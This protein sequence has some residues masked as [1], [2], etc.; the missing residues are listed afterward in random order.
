MTAT[1]LAA[2]ALDV[3]FTQLVRRGLRGI[4]LRGSLPTVP[5]IW[6]ANHHS[7][8]DGFVARAVLQEMGTP[9]SLLMDADNLAA[10]SFLRHVG[11]IPTAHVRAAVRS[12]LAGRTLIIFPEGELRTAGTLGPLAP[13]AG[14]LA[15]QTAAPLVPVATR[16]VLRAQQYPEAYVDIGAPADGTT[17]AADMSAGLQRLDTELARCPPAAPLPGF[18][19]VVRGRASWDERLASWSSKLRL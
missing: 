6:A 15:A 12:V 18:H 7:W 10:Y 5:Y 17:L 9:T 4:W 8:W 14:W 11:V 3:G 13:G 16:I 19:E 2:R 1:P